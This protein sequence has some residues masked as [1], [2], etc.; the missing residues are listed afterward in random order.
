MPYDSEFRWVI[1][2]DQ[3]WRSRTN[4]FQGCKNLGRGC[5]FN[6]FYLAT[7]SPGGLCGKCELKQFPDIYIGSAPC[8]KGDPARDTAEP[9]KEIFPIGDLIL[10]Q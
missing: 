3:S 7:Y 5:D 1:T 2:V 10:L 4:G 9:V 8:G 6:G